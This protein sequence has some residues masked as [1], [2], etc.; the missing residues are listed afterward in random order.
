MQGKDVREK[1]WW[2]KNKKKVKTTGKMLS[3]FHNHPQ[4][5][6]CQVNEQEL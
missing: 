3:T 2:D 6:N 5:I 1:K 4:I